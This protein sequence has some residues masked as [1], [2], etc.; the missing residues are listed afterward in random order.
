VTPTS[1]T[2]LVSWKRW[3]AWY[4]VLLQ[5]SKRRAWFRIVEYEQIDI[6]IC[7]ALNASAIVTHYRIAQ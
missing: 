6:P 1:Y 5:F 3:F 4:P 7:S 2:V